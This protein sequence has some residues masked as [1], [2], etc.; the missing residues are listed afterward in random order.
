MERNDLMFAVGFARATDI[1]DD[2]HKPPALHQCSAARLPDTIELLEEDLIV[3]VIPKL[4]LVVRVF[5][6]VEVGRRGHHKVH[7][8][9]GDM[10]NLPR[11]AQ[12]QSMLGGNLLE[13]SAQGTEGTTV[14]G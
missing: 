8:L 9:L 4:S 5:L 3:V 2:N 1:A 12:E 6:E 13:R 7:R 11:V 10:T 14:L